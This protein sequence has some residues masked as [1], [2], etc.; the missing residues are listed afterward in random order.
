MPGNFFTSVWLLGSTIA[1]IYMTKRHKQTLLRS[2]NKQLNRWQ[3]GMSVSTNFLKPIYQ[4]LFTP[5]L[6][7]AQ[8]QQNRFNYGWAR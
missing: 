7:T 4:M 6:I 1:L 5:F 2:G 8:T 3:S